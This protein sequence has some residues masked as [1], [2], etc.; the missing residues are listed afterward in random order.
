MKLKNVILIG[1]SLGF[2][3]ILIYD[4]NNRY[5]YDTKNNA[6]VLL[7]DSATIHYTTTPV[8]K[9]NEYYITY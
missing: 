2:C 5:E 6:N 3:G 7:S 1:L 4:E 9:N 8:F